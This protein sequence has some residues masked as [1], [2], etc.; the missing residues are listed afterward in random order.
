VK[1]LVPESRPSRRRRSKPAKE[2][3][4]DYYPL[5][6]I[7]IPK[8]I[9][10]E[11]AA[12]S[13]CPDGKIAVSTRRGEIWMIENAF[14]KPPANVKF[15]RFASGLHEVL[16]LAYRDGWLYAMQRCELTKLKDTDGDG[17]ATYSRPS[18]T[19]GRSPGDYHEYAFGSKFDKGGQP[20]GGALP[21]GLLHKRRAVPRL[22][23]ADHAPR[24]R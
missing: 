13:R 16:G 7:P 14:E 24:E 10:L 4:E 2:S 22:V 1:R 3:E 6:K 23:R 9:V 12:S 11:A 17:R 5:I 19:S 15:T 8:D 18:A 21:D 20:L